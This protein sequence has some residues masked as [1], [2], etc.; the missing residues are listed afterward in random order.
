VIPSIQTLHPETARSLSGVFFDIDDTFT[1]HGR[2]RA[3]AYESLWALKESGLWAVPVT[4]RPAGWCDHIARMWPVDGV[5]GENGALYFWFD[6]GEGK[7]KKRFHDPEEVRAE[8]RQRLVRIEEEILASVPG[9]AT[10]SDQLYRETDL[11]IDYCEDVTPLEREAVDRI[12]GIFKKHG[13]RCKVSSIHVN[14]WFG[15]YDKLGMTK[16]LVQERWGLNLDANRERFL[17]CGDSPNDEP[18]FE[19]FP[20]TVGVKN[21]LNFADRMTFLPSFVA[22]REGGEGFAEIVE[23]VLQGR[24]K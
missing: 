12:C 5:V 22:S 17:F 23:T 14:G 1:S 8:K 9:S 18:M 3:L 10:A 7:L 21:V 4:G 6:E 13:A 2:I 20:T 15:D 19:Y 16:T 24:A 11:A